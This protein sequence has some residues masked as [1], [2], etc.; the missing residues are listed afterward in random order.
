VRVPVGAAFAGRRGHVGDCYDATSSACWNSRSRL[1]LCRAVLKL[2]PP[3]AEKANDPIGGFQADVARQLK[4]PPKGEVSCR[5]EAPRG[6]M[7]Y[8]LVSDGS[9]HPYRVR[10]RTGSFSACGL[11]H[12]IMKGLFLA[13]VVTVVGSFDIV[14]PEVDR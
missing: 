8:Y 10:V 11:F 4:K 1:R 14:V 6:E 2:L 9:K 3:S 12:R 13:D 5:T 7:G